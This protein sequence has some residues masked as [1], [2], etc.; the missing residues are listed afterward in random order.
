[1]AFKMLEMNNQKPLRLVG[2]SM[3]HL[4]HLLGRHLLVESRNRSFLGLSMRVTRRAAD[5]RSSSSLCPALRC[6]AIP[7]ATMHQEIRWIWVFFLAG[8]AVPD[9]VYALPKRSA[10][11]V[12]G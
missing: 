1:M 12:T 11:V 4:I 2:R 8:N 6:T 7:A 3:A 5:G 9:V 10:L